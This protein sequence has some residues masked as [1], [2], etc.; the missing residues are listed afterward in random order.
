MINKVKNRW[1]DITLRSKFLLIILIACIL[2]GMGSLYAFHNIKKAYNQE[3]YDKSVQLMTLLAESIQNELDRVIYDSENMISDKSLQKNLS[4]IFRSDDRECIFYASRSLEDRIL[5]L[6]FY[7]TDIESLCLIDSTGKQYGRYEFMNTI[8]EWD[9]EKMASVG[10]EAKG[11]EV[12]IFN[13]EFTGELIMVRDIREA[14]DFTL[15]SIGTLIMKVKLD[16]IV[17]RVCKPL[18]DADM[19]PLIAIYYNGDEMYGNEVLTGISIPQ[20]YAVYDSEWGKF[21]CSYYP[22]SKTGWD[23]MMALPYDSIFQ[24]V[25]HALMV[26]LWILAGTFIF[27][28][29][30]GCHMTASIVKHLEKLILQCDAFG[31][32]EYVAVRDSSNP[33]QKRKDEIGKLYRHFDYM[34]AENKK[35]IQEIYVKQQLL[36]ETQV[37]N[38]RAQ[39]RSHFIYNTLEAIYCLAVGCEDKR[40]G[41][42]SSLLGKFLHMTLKE[43]RSLITIRE[44]MEIAAAYLK[45]QSIR[46]EERLAIDIHIENRYEDISIPFMTIQPIVENAV[47]YGIENMLE[48]GKIWVYCREK[49][50]FA[51]LIVEDNG[52]EIDPD[53]I[54][55]LERKEIAPKGLGIGLVNIQKRLKLL[56]SEQCGIFITREEDRNQVIIRLLAE[57]VSEE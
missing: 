56:L 3:L 29:L 45:I 43:Q 51:E 18:K 10:R 47:L 48:G 44:D 41:E 26:S 49:G 9:L 20:K 23:Y 13:P 11:R 14:Q 5:E 19:E 33:H 21:L 25:N 55:K 7:S 37:S 50:G 32:G 22:F 2:I 35:M 39:I 27:V 8:E 52:E 17:T 12:W 16:N 34:A 31:R 6:R 28:I 15:N 53:V 38:L 24:T 4:D 1:N 46:L 30:S 36:L 42:M 57:K 40:I 54:Q